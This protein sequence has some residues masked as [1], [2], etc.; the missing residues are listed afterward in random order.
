MA[1]VPF[2]SVFIEEG[3]KLRP[4]QQVRIGG[5]SFGPGVSI[6]SGVIIGGIDLAQFTGN[7][8]EIET[9]GNTIVIKG[10]YESSSQSS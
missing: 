10:I 1:R 2:N 6:S 9:E 4:L 3:G 8:L 7:D 5:V